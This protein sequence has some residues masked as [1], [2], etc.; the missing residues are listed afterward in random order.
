MTS[1][2]QIMIKKCKIRPTTPTKY[3]CSTSSP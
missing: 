3:F 1:S 2:P